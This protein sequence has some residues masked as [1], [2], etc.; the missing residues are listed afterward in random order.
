MT[1]TPATS[2]ACL[3][4][5]EFRGR[6]GIARRDATPPVGIYA[7]A[8][9]SAVHDTAEGVHRPLLATCVVFQDSQ[10]RTE[11]VFLTLDVMVFWQEEAV[12]LRT[13]ILNRMR[14][15]PHQL[16]VH[17]SHSHSSPMLLRKHADRAGGQYI[18]PYLDSLP[19][20]FCELIVEAR[21]A[22]R[23]A[24]LGWTYGKCGLAFNRDSIDAASNRDI[25][26]INPRVPA[27]DTVLV[28]RITDADGKV[29]GTI[30]NYAAHP[31]SL[32]GGNK[33]LSSDYIGAMRE[34]IEQQVGGTCVFFHGASG[35]TTPRRSYESDVAAADQNGRELGYAALAAL[36]AMA[37]PGQQLEYRGIEESGTALGVWQLAAKPAVS[38]VLAAQR[39]TTTLPI[40]DMPTRADI[41]RA[42]AAKPDRVELERL[43]RALDRRTVVGDGTEGD[44]Y[45]TVWRLG[46]A[47]IL[48][49]PAE[50]YSRFQ[51]E[52]RA[53][54]PGTTV[55]VLN[56]TDGC[57]N[58]LPIPDAFQ[59]DV[60]QVRV[61]LYQQ[62][63]MEK[64]LQLAARAIERMS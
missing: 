19:D 64:V 27:D 35:D 56:A 50:P 34:L 32:G 46:D 61:A 25:C 14:L 42:M 15:E 24:T 38:S 10:A 60:Y 63:S 31:V 58:Y 20:L 36:S 40:R 17:P 9:G 51:V 22:C 1:P 11:L 18:A 26:G 33:L 44:F 13:A 21:A 37:P 8:W 4:H 45:F 7:R 2:R 5:P 23:E 16:M 59:R 3:A 57:L 62:G 52:L 48:A 49:T 6:I 47:F 39:V 12:R 41:E 30:V 53:K 55:A 29:F 28:G 43:E 54:F